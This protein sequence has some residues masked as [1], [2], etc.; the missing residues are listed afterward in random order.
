MPGYC[1]SKHGLVGTIRS[2]AQSLGPLGIRANAVCPGAMDTPMLAESLG[3]AGE[4][5]AEQ[6]KQ[7][8]PL[9]YISDPAEVARAI[10]FMLSDDASYITGA[11]LPVD[12]GMLA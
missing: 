12:G 6:M 8:I 11:A 9:G 1:A 10:R 3:A 2:I 4:D 7:M 5:M